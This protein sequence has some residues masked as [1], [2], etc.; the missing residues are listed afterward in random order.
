M[1]A[2]QV[3]FEVE[4]LYPPHQREFVPGFLAVG[5]DEDLGLRTEMRDQTRG[6]AAHRQEEYRPGIE[7]SAS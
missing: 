3:A 1:V 7:A 6:Q 5:R 2:I 4:R